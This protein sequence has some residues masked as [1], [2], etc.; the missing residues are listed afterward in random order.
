M[1]KELVRKLD[2]DVD[3]GP[4]GLEAVVQN[5]EAGNYRLEDGETRPVI[6]NA[7]TSELVKGT[8]QPRQDRRLVLRQI[9]QEMRDAFT[10]KI[11]ANWDRIVDSLIKIAVEKGDVRAHKL[12][13]EHGLGR[14][15]E[16]PRS[17]AARLCKN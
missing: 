4:D 5:V 17:P 12:L 9:E 6:K 1:P 16:S 11:G 3:Y 15:R 10:T 14:P 7:L 8:G 2:P 13:L